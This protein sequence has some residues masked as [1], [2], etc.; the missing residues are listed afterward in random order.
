MPAEVLAEISGERGAPPPPPPPRSP[1]FFLTRKLISE[2][3]IVN[4]TR[5]VVVGASDTALALL[6]LLTAVPYIH[7]TSLYL[8]SPD[9]AARLRSPRGAQ[10]RTPPVVVVP[11]TWLRSPRGAQARTPPSGAVVVVPSTWRYTTVCPRGRR[12]APTRRRLYRA[13]FA[14][15]PTSSRHSISARGSR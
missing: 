7:F 5:I 13:R 9:A 12:R 2:P 6:E 10:A 1:L 3:K 8:L 11:S 14:T 15:R 4:N